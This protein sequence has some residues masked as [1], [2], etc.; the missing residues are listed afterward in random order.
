MSTTKRQQY[1][2]TRS[3]AQ[4]APA[5]KATS[6]WTEPYQ[7][8]SR[9]PEDRSEPQIQEDEAQRPTHDAL[10]EIYNRVHE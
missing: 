3:A 8:R 4:T 1:A 7:E 2:S 6:P 10:S 9:Q 5:H